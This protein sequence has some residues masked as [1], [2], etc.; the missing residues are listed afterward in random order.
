MTIHFHEGPH[1]PPAGNGGWLPAESDEEIEIVP[2]TDEDPSE[3]SSSEEEDPSERSSS[4]DDEGPHEEVPIEGQ[5]MAG[6]PYD[7]DP[8]EDLPEEAAAG[9]EAEPVQAPVDEFQQ[10]VDEVMED[11]DEMEDLAD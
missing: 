2:E 5:L 7:F 1:S 4:D 9:V 3:G 6:D 8:I 11:L 10:L